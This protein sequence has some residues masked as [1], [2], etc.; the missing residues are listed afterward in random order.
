MPVTLAQLAK[1]EVLPLRKGVMMNI[2]RYAKV[3][4]TLP[5]ETVSALKSVATRVRTFPQGGVFRPFNGTYTED[6]G[7][8]LEQVW[9]SVY[10]F[11]GE[12]QYDR[13]LKKISSS[14]I[15]DPKAQLLAMK[16]QAMSYQF[17]QYFIQGDHATDPD[18]FEG[19]QKRVSLMPARQTV[20]AAGAAA[21]A[22]DVTGAIGNV[23]IFLNRWETAFARANG[24]Q[25]NAIFM[26]ENMKLGFMRA[27]RYGNVGQAGMGLLDTTKDSFEREIITYK[28]AP[29]VDM[30]T[31]ADQVTEIIPDTQVAGDGGLDAT[32]VYF[33]SYGVEQGITGIQLSALETD[34]MGEMQTAPADMTRIEWWM[35]LAGFGSYG[36]VRL[37]NVEGASNWTE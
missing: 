14:Y 17:N 15:V 5:F 1:M 8:D 24:G 34:D 37:R 20:W 3:F 28:G 10:A 21:A 25:V 32:S 9:E 31:Q 27:M 36:I 35:G 12:Q 6:T 2:L 7:G 22:L 19:L 11:G 13:V 4:E 18:G 29:F 16:L 26:N 23:R 33:V 30:G